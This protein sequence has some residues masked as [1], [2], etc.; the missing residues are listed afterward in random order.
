MHS[1]FTYIANDTT[2]YY[3]CNLHIPQYY[4]Y[5]VSRLKGIVV[6]HLLSKHIP[7]MWLLTEHVFPIKL[8]CVISVYVCH[9]VKSLEVLYQLDWLVTWTFWD[10]AVPGAY[11]LH[12]CRG[13]GQGSRLLMVTADSY[14][15]QFDAGPS[16]SSLFLWTNGITVVLM[17]HAYADGVDHEEIILVPGLK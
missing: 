6:I 11:W 13:W 10:D 17:P 4:T 15:L 3:S 16:V 2:A 7:N 5:S 9:N 8:C 14:W 12:C 1:Y